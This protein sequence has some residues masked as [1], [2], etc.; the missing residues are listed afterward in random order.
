MRIMPLVFKIMHGFELPEHIQ[1]PG[2]PA[3]WKLE[4]SK[5]FRMRYTERCQN[6][7]LIVTKLSNKIV[8]H[9]SLLYKR[10]REISFKLYEQSI[11]DGEGNCLGLEPMH[12]TA[13]L[14]I[15]FSHNG[16]SSGLSTWEYLKLCF[17][18]Q[19]KTKNNFP[20]CFHKMKILVLSSRF[21]Y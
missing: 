12:E 1:K 3:G 11:E 18:S 7:I 14:S 13:K 8:R 16:K 10:E 15:S 2:R 4:H 5:F 19:Y 17:W 21:L 20:S 9:I 6:L